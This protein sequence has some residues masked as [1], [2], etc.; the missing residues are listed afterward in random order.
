MNK[1]ELIGKTIEFEGIWYNGIQVVLG[2]EGIKRTVTNVY[3]GEINVKGSSWS[4]DEMPIND[5]DYTNTQITGNKL[6]IHSTRN[7]YMSIYNIH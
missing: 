3:R 4:S 2:T 6:Y 5:S 7:D 1:N